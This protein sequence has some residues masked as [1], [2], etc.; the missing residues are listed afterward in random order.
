MSPSSLFFCRT[1]SFIVALHSHT[2]AIIVRRV[3]LTTAYN[4]LN[5]DFTAQAISY[6]TDINHI[7]YPKTENVNDTVL[8]SGRHDCL[9]P[10]VIPRACKEMRFCQKQ[11]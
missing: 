8:Q 6:C 11:C 3:R 1:F 2:L 7:R 9:H 5:Q 10:L 4:L